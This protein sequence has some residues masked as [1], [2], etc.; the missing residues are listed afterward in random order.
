MSAAVPAKV[1]LCPINLRGIL[2]RA[3]ADEGAAVVEEHVA[4]C[5]A[6]VDGGGGG[7][8]EETGV[9]GKER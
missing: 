7:G 8:V 6:L 3:S 9:E 2:K 1:W 4:V 5:L